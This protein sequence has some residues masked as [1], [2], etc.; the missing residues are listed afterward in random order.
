MTLFERLRQYVL[1][2]RKLHRNYIR[3]HTCVCNYTTVGR[4][5]DLQHHRRIP[6]TTPAAV[7]S[8]ATNK[9]IKNTAIQ[10]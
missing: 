6:D 8:K 3:M 1:P 2:H 7:A 5:R 10:G 9:I 4:E